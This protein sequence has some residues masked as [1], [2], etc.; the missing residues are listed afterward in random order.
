MEEPE[1]D[2]GFTLDFRNPTGRPWRE[3]WEDNLWLMCEAEKMG[4]DCLLLQQ[5]FFTDDGYGPSLPVFLALLAERTKNIRI[6]AYVYVLPIQNA[7]QIAQETS[8]LDHISGGRLDVTV[9]AGHRPLEY[10]AFGMSPKTRPSRMDE[11]IEVLKKA[12]TEQPFSYH[13]K[14]YD[15]EN[16]TVRPEPLQQPHPPLW[17]GATAPAGAYRAGRYGA[18]LAAASVEDDFYEAYFAGLAEAGVKRD[19]VQIS[20]SWPLTPYYF[21]RW[22]FFRLIRTEMGDPDLAL[23]FG[24]TPDADAYRDYELIGTPETILETIRPMCERLPLTMLV[25]MGPA[26]GIPIRT[27]SYEAVK[28]FAEEMLPVIKQW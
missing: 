3:H 16:I 17:V 7:A 2:V 18:H 8:V 26:S 6:A 25:H 1:L 19:A 5:H 27:E 20:N 10:Q 21:H 28:L 4:Y 13:G 24:R 14:Y 12:W 11:G 23:E 9:A 15:L 22:D